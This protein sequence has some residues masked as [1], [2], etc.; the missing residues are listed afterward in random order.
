L[1]QSRI[2]TLYKIQEERQNAKEKIYLHQIHIKRWLDKKSTGK[3]EFSVGDLVLKWDKTHKDKGKHTK[4]QSLWIRSFVV[5]E[6]LGQQTYRL[7]SLDGKIDSLPINGQYL[8]QY[9]Q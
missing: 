7:Q 8:K 4:F 1:V 3:N 5:H 6:N 2:N 9:F